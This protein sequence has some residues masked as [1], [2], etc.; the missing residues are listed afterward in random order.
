MKGPFGLISMVLP[1]V[2]LD[3]VVNAKQGEVLP[4]VQ[5]LNSSLNRNVLC[6]MNGAVLEIAQLN[7]NLYP[8]RA[9]ISIIKQRTNVRN[10]PKCLYGQ[11]DSS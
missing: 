8:L 4:E 7:T 9:I 11:K 5:F 10:M 1:K 6:F 3:I 2:T